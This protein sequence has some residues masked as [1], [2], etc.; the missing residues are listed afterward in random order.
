M[1]RT[2]TPSIPP[3]PE[4]SPDM[5]RSNPYLAGFAAAYLGALCALRFLPMPR[6]AQVVVALAPVV[7]FA[8]YLRRWLGAVRRLDELQRLIRLEALGIAY[9]LTPLLIMTIGLLEMV[10]AIRHDLV[11][12]L[13][14]WPVVFWL[15]FIGLI[16]ARRLYR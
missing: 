2:D 8:L 10:G 13:R 3:G 1:E 4:C 14:I 11:T 16:A 9:P 5:S 12:Y 6:A 7:V 15:Y